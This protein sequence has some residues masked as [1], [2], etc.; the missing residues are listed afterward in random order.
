MAPVPQPLSRS[1]N[2]A[3]TTE[4]GDGAAAKHHHR[5]LKA[6][7]RPRSIIDLRSAIH[8]REPLILDQ[9]RLE[10]VGATLE[11]FSNI[12]RTYV[13]SHKNEISTYEQKH[14]EDTQAL[15]SKL[16]DMKETIVAEQKVADDLANSMST[17]FL[18]PITCLGA[19][20]RS[21]L[22]FFIL[23]FSWFLFYMA[24][25]LPFQFSL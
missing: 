25:A 16:R 21:C 5:T 23:L 9:A 3:V 19:A 11:S 17:L 4:N 2:N 7:K 12:V 10:P 18:V 13:E 15:L 24:N 8:S 22:S 20:Y 14:L 6:Q 1:T